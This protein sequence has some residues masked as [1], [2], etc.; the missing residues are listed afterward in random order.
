MNKDDVMWKCPQ[1]GR[2]VP[3]SLYMMRRGYG[4]CECEGEY[5]TRICYWQFDKFIL[6]E[7]DTIPKLIDI[8]TMSID[9]EVMIKDAINEVLDEEL[10]KSYR[11][12]YSRGFEEGADEGYWKGYEEKAK[13]SSEESYSEGYN[14]GHNEGYDSG[15]TNGYKK[16]IRIY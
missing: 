6:D 4:A 15:Y 5:Y 16:A 12:G 8:K 1:C 2:I 11:T 14:R 3:D 10:E 9:I 7:D 13:C